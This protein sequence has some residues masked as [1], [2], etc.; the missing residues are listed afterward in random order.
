MADNQQNTGKET[1]GANNYS[2]ELKLAVKNTQDMVKKIL[3]ITENFSETEKNH[4]QGILTEMEEEFGK[5]K[6]ILDEIK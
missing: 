6:Q 4:N 2:E 3:E 5:L 1:K